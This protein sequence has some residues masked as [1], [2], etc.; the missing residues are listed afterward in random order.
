MRLFAADLKD[1]LKAVA[2]A[3]SARPV[4][5]LAAAV[6]IDSLGRF[7]ATDYDTWIQT[8]A[9]AI[10]SNSD[11][12]EVAVSHKLLTAIVNV[13]RGDTVTLDVEQ[14]RLVITAGQAEWVAPLMK[15]DL[16]AWPSL[17]AK[18]GSADAA[19]L[20][21]S[22]KIVGIA[23]AA[24]DTIGGLNGVQLA[25]EGDRL[26]L[27]TTDRYRLHRDEIRFTPAGDVGYTVLVEAARLSA[28]V[29]NLTGELTLHADTDSNLLAVADDKTTVI[30]RE[31][32]AGFPATSQL[33]TA[34]DSSQAQ[35]TV[36]ASDL[37]DAF[38]AAMPT[39]QDKAGIEIT[40][41]RDSFTLAST[42]EGGSAR[43]PVAE[44][45]HVGRGLVVLVNPN[46]IQPTLAALGGTV[47]I[48]WTG[49]NRALRI[50]K[51]GSPGQYVVM[52]IRHETSRW[53][54]SQTAHA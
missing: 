42:D 6:V 27:S 16:P 46:F 33:L 31:I 2:P 41:D 26:T 35:T 17:P 43:I 21:A 51:A 44:H 49:P 30:L 7:S 37:A 29:R 23:A 40:V 32:D 12:F 24:D 5:P 47:V 28:S 45:E 34:F 1:A 3:V 36:K 54:D 18:W 14:H 52:A 53:L 10:S 19:E 39:M 22:L 9:P 38:K 25:A 4:I 15:T 50:S 48:D 8:T 20:D 13:A 11:A